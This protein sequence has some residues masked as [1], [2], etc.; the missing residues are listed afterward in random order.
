M[1]RS[2][3]RA[4]EIKVMDQVERAMGKV[5]ELPEPARSRVRR[6]MAEEYLMRLGEGDPAPDGQP[7]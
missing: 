1:A 7:S 6:W 4:A 3:A 2:E 5:D